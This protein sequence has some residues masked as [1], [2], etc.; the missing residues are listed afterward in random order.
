M[1][2]A[3]VGRAHRRRPPWAP[4]LGLRDCPWPHSY[5][6]ALCAYTPCLLLNI[7]T[8]TCCT[9]QL[10]HARLPAH[11]LLPPPPPPLQMRREGNSVILSGLKF[12]GGEMLAAQ[13][14][15]HPE[16]WEEMEVG[17]RSGQRCGACSIDSR[18]WAPATA[19][20]CRAPTARCRLGRP[21]TPTL[22]QP[23]Q[24]MMGEM[25]GGSGGEGEEGV[26]AMRLRC[27]RMMGGEGGEEDGEG[28]GEQ[29][30]RLEVPHGCRAGRVAVWCHDCMMRGR[31]V[32]EEERGCRQR[33][34]SAHAASRRVAPA[35]CHSGRLPPSPA[36]LKA[37]SG[38]LPPRQVSKMLSSEAL[39]APA[40]GKAADGSALVL[41]LQ[42]A[43]LDE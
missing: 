17:L 40:V 19:A 18:S 7:Q 15:Q 4:A 9:A 25:M 14:P 31:K 35:A 38:R 37:P 24:E 41:L 36:N 26:R 22:A 43:V 16:T 10:P 27:E 39:G 29:R 34:A 13:L 5:R 3:S 30:L 21:L 33:R 11:R 20:L 1:A 32:R 6:L 42:G 28:A 8:T 23:L 12:R 2:A